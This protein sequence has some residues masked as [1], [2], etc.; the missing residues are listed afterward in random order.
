MTAC[1]L[2]WIT[3]MDT[4]NLPIYTINNF[5]FRYPFSNTNIH[6]SG[7]INIYPKSKVLLSAR[8][9]LGKS[10]LLYA[11]KGLIPKHIYGKISGEILFNGQPVANLNKDQTTQIGL[12]MQN[13]HAQII[14]TTVMEELAFGLECLGMNKEDIL[15]R[16]EQYASWFKIKHLLNKK[17][18]EL[19]GGQKQQINFISIIL[20]N[21]QVI[22]MDEPTAFLDP[23]SANYFI[24]VFNE[25]SKDKTII[26]IEHNLAYLKDKVSNYL[27]IDQSGLLYEDNVDKINWTNKFVSSAIKAATQPVPLIEIKHYQLKNPHKYIKDFTINQGEI[28]GILGDNGVGKTTLLNSLAKLD[29]LNTKTICYKGTDL[30]QIKTKDYF[31]QVTLLWQNPE[32]HFLF[33]RVIDEVHDA[34]LLTLMKLD[35]C[36]NQNPFTLSEGQKRRL[37]LAIVWMLNRELYLLDEPT[38]GQD[39]LNKQVLIDL[40]LQMQAQGKTFVIVSHDL[41]FL[42]AINAKL[43]YLDDQGLNNYVA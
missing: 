36:L 13:P 37:S 39:A 1:S 15:N 38:F 33:N 28:I 26:I 16:I 9:G 20:P 11:L 41:E 21:P 4:T 8:S 18:D 32:N 35:N 24:E 14:T 34:Q 12:L 17:T 3:T 2:E 19:S 43:F 29:D 23:K 7:L 31:D 25:I 22:L 42:Q 5:S 27:Q 6:L 10:T 30:N 40:V